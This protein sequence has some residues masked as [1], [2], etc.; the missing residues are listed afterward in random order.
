MLKT[1]ILAY[2]IGYYGIHVTWAIQGK[3]ISFNGLVFAQGWQ[4]FFARTLLAS[5]CTFWTWIL[6]F[7]L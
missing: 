5:G 1:L 2:L 6:L 7:V 4:D 3:N